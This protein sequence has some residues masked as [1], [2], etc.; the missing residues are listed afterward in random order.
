[1]EFWW[2]CV[3]IEEKTNSRLAIM[4]RYEHLLFD[5]D[6]TL[7]DFESNS[8]DALTELHEEFG[9]AAFGIEDAAEFVRVYKIINESFWRKYRTGKIT[10][11]YLR[12]RRF[13]LA[14][15]RFGF[16]N[17]QLAR[18]F[19][20]RYIEI[21]P[22]KTKLMPGALETLDHL[23]RQYNLCLV[24]NGF[25]ETQATKISSSGLDKFFEEVV[26]SEQAGSKKPDPRFFQ[27][28]LKQIRANSQECL[29]IG[30]NLEADITGAKNAGIDQVFY[31]PERKEHGEK[32][33]FEI[34]ELKELIEML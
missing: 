9:L 22:L 31:N 17:N 16:E 24:T 33:T 34:S 32:V 13:S 12:N 19:G 10:K 21:C 30:D 6:H 27:F 3:R 7:W 1:M 2:N 28:A 5:L 20:D 18:Q 11:G 25:S 14:F 23:H 4:R 29:L 8:T 15:S 26:T